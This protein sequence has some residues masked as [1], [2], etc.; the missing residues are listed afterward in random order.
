MFSGSNKIYIG[1][2]NNSADNLFQQVYPTAS[3][4]K[5]YITVPLKTRN[6]DVFRVVVSDPATVVTLDGVVQPTSALI[7]NFYYQF[8]SQTTHVITGDKPIQ[9]IQYA[10]TQGD[11]IT[12][13]SVAG[14]I[15]DPEMIY[16][17]PLEQNISQ[18]TL[19]STDKYKILNGFINRRHLFSRV[20]YAV[21]T[22]SITCESE[23]LVGSGA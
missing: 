13:K 20:G 12:G 4:G 21:R 23:P 5:N 6:Y 7:N 22:I 15:G 8:N 10:V 18:V 9:V 1:S 2:P 17:N 11:G 3:W 14:D 19:Y 16:L